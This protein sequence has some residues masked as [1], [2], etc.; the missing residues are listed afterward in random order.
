MKK[1]FLFFL[2]VSLLIVSLLQW[3]CKK[4][5]SKEGTKEDPKEEY[6]SK[7]VGDWKFKVDVRTFNDFLKIDT[8]YSFT[9]DGTIKYGNGDK[10]ILIKYSE[11]DSIIEIVENDGTILNRNVQQAYHGNYGAFEGDNKFQYYRATGMPDIY[12][13]FE[14][15]GT[16]PPEIPAENLP[17]ITTTGSASG[18]LL[19]GALLTGTA[20][21]NGSYTKIFFEYGPTMNYGNTR[22][23]VPSIISNSDLQYICLLITGLTPGTL[24]HFREKAVNSFGTTYGSDLTLTT[25]TPTEPVSDIDG[26]V[27]NTVPIGNQIWIAENLKTTHFNDG[28]AIP[29]VSDDKEWSNLATSGYCWYKNDESTYKN[30]YGAIYNWYTVSTSK[31]CPIGWHVPSENEFRTLTN[32]LGGTIGYNTTFLLAN[33]SNSSLP[34]AN[35]TG[36]TAVE[37]GLRYDFGA[38]EKSVSWWTS[39]EYNSYDHYAVYFNLRNF[40]STPFK[41][42]GHSVR[43]LKD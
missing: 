23:A 24:Y 42:N 33:T 2:S 12:S 7:Y 13:Y 8:A 9:Y 5:D 28:T 22:V 32:S 38:Y 3:S 34:E 30:N 21:A 40:D 41:Q 19:K 1:N 39:T 35:I 31:L 11:K 43:C 25:L 15:H 20:I 4:E 16:R 26:N 6:L 14:L 18:I 29:L 10:E 27:Y 37:A 36:F 17:P